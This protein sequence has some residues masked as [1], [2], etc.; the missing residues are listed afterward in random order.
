MALKI[1]PLACQ[2]KFF[3]F[4]KKWLFSQILTIFR[5]PGNMPSL[6][7][8]PLKRTQEGEFNHAP[9]KLQS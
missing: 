6:S 3:I 9:F 7:I 2:D 1:K 5:N 8:L 4:A